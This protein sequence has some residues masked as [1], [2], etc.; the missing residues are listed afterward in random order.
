MFSGKAIGNIG[1]KTFLSPWA[2]F[3]LQK[4]SFKDVR[5]GSEYS[6]NTDS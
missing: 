5:Q 2:Y 3:I 4:S 6:F 1:K